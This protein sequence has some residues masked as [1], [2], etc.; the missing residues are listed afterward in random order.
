MQEFGIL[1][2][3]TIQMNIQLARGGKVGQEHSRIVM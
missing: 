1:P 2:K 3:S